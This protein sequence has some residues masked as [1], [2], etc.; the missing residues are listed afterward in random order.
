MLLHTF[1]QFRDKMIDDLKRKLGIIS[2]DVAITVMYELNGMI[3]GEDRSLKKKAVSDF[4]V[5][6]LY[7]QDIRNVLQGQD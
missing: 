4:L 3:L 2:T 7:G 5:N 1:E 6:K